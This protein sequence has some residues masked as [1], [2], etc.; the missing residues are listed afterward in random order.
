ML[1][2]NLNVTYGL[3]NGSMGQVVDIIYLN[4]RTP[5]EGQPDVVMVNFTKY[6]GPPF[7]NSHPQLVPIVPV[8]RKKDCHCF[9]CKRKQIP[10]RLGWGTTIHRCQGMTIGEGEAN[11]YIVIHPGDKKFE[12]RN[13][14]ALFVALSR[15]KSAGGEDEDPDFAWH[16]HVLINEDRLCQKVCTE[17]TKA[18]TNEIKRIETITEN[19]KRAYPHLFKKYQ[20][21]PYEFPIQEE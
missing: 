16:P 2:V 3:F 12:A 21:P 17:T 15:A 10:L 6:T 4:G 5:V 9:N 7:I 11:R 19:T 1:T 8:E 20:F 13:P 14:G 18:R